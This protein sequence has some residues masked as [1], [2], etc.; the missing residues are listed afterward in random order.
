MLF[1]LSIKTYLCL[2]TLLILEGVGKTSLVQ[3]LCHDE[4]T[5]NPAYTIGCSV[6]VTVSNSIGT[7]SW[8]ASENAGKNAI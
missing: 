2:M 5:N 1:T 3:L 8:I 7:L 4:A 6:E